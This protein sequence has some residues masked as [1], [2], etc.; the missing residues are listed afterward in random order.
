MKWYLIFT[1]GVLLISLVGANSLDVSKG[2]IYTKISDTFINDDGSRTTIIYSGNIRNVFENGSWKR[3]EDAESLNNYF[4]WGVNYDENYPLE[5]I[6]FNWTTIIINISTIKNSFTPLTIYEYKTNPQNLSDYFL[7]TGNIEGYNEFGWYPT[8]N[9]M[10]LSS[11]IPRTFT[12]KIGNPFSKK[13]IWGSSSSTIQINDTSGY[14]DGYVYSDDTSNNWNYI[15]DI[16]IGDSL[17]RSSNIIIARSAHGIATGVEW[18]IIVR[19]YLPINTSELNDLGD[20]GIINATLTFNVSRSNRNNTIRFVNTSQ[21][22]VSELN[23]SDFPRCGAID[24]P[25]AVAPD[26]FIEK[27]DIGIKTVNI[28]I[29]GIINKTGYTMLGLREAEYDAEDD[30]PPPIWHDAGWITW[31]DSSEANFPP[32][33]TITYSIDTEYPSFSNYWDDNAS[34]IE[35]GTGEFNVTLLST[36]GTVL[37]EINGTNISASNSSGDASVFNATYTFSIND[38]YNYKWHSWSN[39]TSNFY[40]F[41]D[42]RSYTVNESI[43]LNLN[44]PLNNNN[45]INFTSVEFN[46]SVNSTAN[47]INISLYSDYKGN[48]E[49]IDTVS[50]SGNSNQTN[51][52]RNIFDDRG[53]ETYVDD[54]FK[55]NCLSYDDANDFDWGDTN[56]TFSNWDLN[57]TY[58]NTTREGN[59][60]ISLNT[61]G[62][63]DG[64]TDNGDGTCTGTFYAHSSDGSIRKNTLDIGCSGSLW[65]SVHDATIGSLETGNFLRVSVSHNVA[66][67]VCD[68]TIRRGF[69]PFNTTLLNDKTDIISANLYFYVYSITAK[70]NL[71]LYKTFH[72]EGTLSS[73]N[74]NDIGYVGAEGANE[75]SIPNPVQGAD[76]IQINGTGWYN[77]SLNNTGLTWINLTHFTKLGIREIDFDAPDT[78]P[79]QNQSDNAIININTSES[80]GTGFDPYLNITYKKVFTGEYTSKYFTNNSNVS[81]NNISWSN[82]SI[83]GTNVSVQTRTTN[84]VGCNS[85][86][87]SWNSNHNNPSEL[88]N[89]SATCLQY[90]A[91]FQ[92]N[93]SDNLP[94]LNNAYINYSGVVPVDTC[95]CP[96]S[97][98]WIVECSD[99][100]IITSTCHIGSNTLQLTGSGTFGILAEI[101]AGKYIQSPLCPIYGIPTGK[102]HINPT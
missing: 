37:L 12:I 89:S 59:D 82:N 53:G 6:D 86:W 88:I 79:A 33:L 1:I 27:N 71:S 84:I 96:S 63:L 22:N 60:N 97:G 54:G 17:N 93:D 57:S 15:H 87:S 65:N 70:R 99:N 73:S 48:W 51:F 20:I 36:N 7:L 35:S 34:L 74:Y 28:S 76:R 58:L 41:S 101:Y 91:I 98:N 5:I 30:E 83:S 52:T 23:L 19:G 69:F 25:T 29:L 100:C 38:I 11:S 72:V 9:Y 10:I 24:D 85:G 26:F 56:R 42:L 81:W 49:I 44:F 66:L 45:T 4:S 40:N 14:G 78:E 31:I 90:K 55:W 13:I 18:W 2:Q 102:L 16:S 94:L 64:H 39:G 95:S 61:V 3:R 67:P 8:A 32:Y 62:C 75:A 47:L 43:K 50:I 21:Y 77:F 80:E 92:T 46:C 68:T